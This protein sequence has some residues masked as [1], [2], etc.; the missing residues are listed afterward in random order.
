VSADERIVILHRYAI[1]PEVDDVARKHGWKFA[2]VIDRKDNQFYEEIWTVNGDRAVV[3]FIDDHFV[4]V[5][6][7]VITG[8]DADETERTLRASMHT[9][10]EAEVVAAAKSG[11]AKDRANAIRSLAATTTD[12]DSPELYA[13]L[14]AAAD[15]RDKF[16]RL[17]TIKAMAR[18]ASKRHW[19]IIQRRGAKEKDK[20]LRP[21]IDALILAYKEFGKTS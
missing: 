5:G 9:M 14:D 19:S 2:Q 15:D 7:V 17:A 20:D 12:P 8:P 11:D 10:T 18:M 21:E 3:R 4:G 6:Y 1:A 16:I 13:L